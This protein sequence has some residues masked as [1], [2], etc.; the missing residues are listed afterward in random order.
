MNTT[1]LKKLGNLDQLCGIRD[2]RLVSGRGEGVRVTEFHNA[3][4]L[5]FSILPDKGMDIYDLSYKGVNLAFKTKNGIV[6]PHA[7]SASNGEFVEQWSGGAMV[8]CG[9]DNVGGYCEVDGFRHQQHGRYGTIPASSFGTKGF[10]DGDNYILRAEGE[11][12]QTRFFGHHLGLLRTVETGINDK[13]IRIHDVITNYEAEDEPYMLLYHCN[14]GYPLLS[15]DSIL[16]VTSGKTT[17]FSGVSNDY[18]H[19]TPPVDGIEEEVY[20]HTELKKK[21]YSVLYNRELGLGVYVAFDTENLPTMVEWKNMKSHDYALGMEPT[22]IPAFKREDALKG[23]IAVLP[24]YGSVE[25]TLEI[26]VLD[27]NDEIDSFLARI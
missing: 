19:M 5:S 24:A 3:A 26:G 8:T 22:N 13:A 14:F 1:L 23:N 27:G 17:M 11:M 16:K 4:G 12:H 18:S 20:F 2:S 6:S 25:N 10:W 9:L 21:A 15:G 7:A